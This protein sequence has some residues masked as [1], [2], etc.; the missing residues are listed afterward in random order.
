M[1]DSL[2]SSANLLI[3]D[4]NLSPATLS[5]VCHRATARGIKIVFA[6]TSPQKCINI[7]RAGALELVDFVAADELEARTILTE[8]GMLDD[9]LDESIS[10]SFAKRYGVV[11]IKIECLEENSIQNS[12]AEHSFRRLHEAGMVNAL[13]LSLSIQGH[14]L[15]YIDLGYHS[16]E[17]C[18]KALRSVRSTL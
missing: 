12:D 16:A 18:G 15:E 13:F 1:Q 8:A 4:G 11:L 7:V 6:A 17:H 2:L 9:M 5:K 3:L 14:N 10:A